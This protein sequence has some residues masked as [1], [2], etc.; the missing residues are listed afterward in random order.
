MAGVSQFPSPVRHLGEFS[1]P[2]ET[3]PYRDSRDP[4]FQLLKAPLVGM[5]KRTKAR[6]L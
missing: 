1:A 3:K 2:C 6:D 5:L 4:A